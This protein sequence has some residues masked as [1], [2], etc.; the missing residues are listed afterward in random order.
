MKK[1]NDIKKY[2]PR[3][4]AVGLSFTMICSAAGVTAVSSNSEKSKTEAAQSAAADTKAAET[5]AAADSK[6]FSK[7]ETVYVIAGAD[8]TPQKV[9]VSDWIK[10]PD[11][12]KT[13]KDKSNLKD[14]ENVK[15]DETFT[16]DENNMLEWA[17]DGN[18]IY[19]RGNSDDQLP[20]AVSVQYE[21]DGKAVSPKELA[22]KSGKLKMTFNYTNRQCEEVKIGDKK[23]KI[24]VPFVMLTGMML[25]NEK[26]T[27][28]TVSNGKVLNDGSH[29]YVA[30][31]ALPGLKESLALGD[32][33]DLP[34]SVEITADVTDF[35][36]ATTLTVATNEIFNDIDTSKLDGKLDELKKKLNEL[37]DGID[38]LADGSSQLYAGL[39]TLL[40]KS[41]ELIDGVNQLYDGAD[42]LQS[43]AASLDD[44]AGK[45]KDGAAALDSGVGTLKDGITT[46]DNGAG[47]LSDGASQVDS[48]V[49]ELK[50]HIATLAGGLDQ[51]STNSA[52]LR[53][54]AKQ[55]FDTLL[56]EANKQIAAAGLTAD[57]LTIENYATVLDAL[58]AQLSDE[59]ITKLANDTAYNTVSATVN[60]QRDLIRQAVE[61]NVRKQVTDGV[62]AAAGLGMD[63]E[64]YEAA[65]AAGQVPDDVQ[66]QVSA[67]VA[68]QMSGMGGTIDAN[69]DAQIASIIETNMQ[70]EEV[71][72]QIAQAVA[73]AKGGRQSLEAL[74]AQLDSYNTFYQGIISYTDGVDQA[75]YGAQQILGG[76]GTLKDGTASLAYGAGELKGGTSQIKNGS[77]ELKNGSSQLKSGTADLKSGTEQL[78]AGAVRLFNGL[79]TFKNGTGALVDGVTKLKDG[80][81]QLDEGMQKLK[82]E[83]ADA[84]VKAVNGDVKGLV[85]RVKAIVAVSKNYKTFSGVSD[86][87]DG[88]VDF[89]FKT[90]SISKEEPKEKKK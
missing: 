58:I 67:G 12:A 16:I 34:S 13:I 74:K 47:D 28:V 29:T 80:S 51:I 63:S 38:K 2:L 89:I 49:A 37:T 85:D 79:G 68:T 73:K 43:G 21:I 22:G 50:S 65:V 59:N 25:D 60:S 75:S 69:T 44:G 48:G 3:A 36:L 4:L 64:A 77:G 45:L 11:K 8:G 33:L 40:D 24:Y 19:Y 9:I 31:F 18:D 88:K 81:Q 23:E 54:G 87:T 39:S 5:K 84:I 20:V 1:N 6:K 66:A 41:G 52:Q 15:G 82:K 72:T 35:E 30:G 90:D 56:N 76:T 46:L 70:S 55:V 86:E 57:P 26:F 61:A 10:N 71:Q 27:N 14:I 78:H 7:E 32:N 53:G 17:A 62:L 83:G 42:K